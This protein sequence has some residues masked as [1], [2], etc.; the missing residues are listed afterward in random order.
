MQP[1][2]QISNAADLPDLHDKLSARYPYSDCDKQVFTMIVFMFIMI[3][4]KTKRAPSSSSVE[5]GPVS[6]QL[7]FEADNTLIPHDLPL[8]VRRRLNISQN[9]PE[10]QPQGRGQ[11][12]A[13]KVYQ[14]F[15]HSSSF[16]HVMTKFRRLSRKLRPG[17]IRLKRALEKDL[18]RGLL[19]LVI[20]TLKNDENMQ[21]IFRNIY[22]GETDVKTHIAAANQLDILRLT[23]PPQPNHRSQSGELSGQKESRIVTLLCLIAEHWVSPK[24]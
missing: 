20:V 13:W 3:L 15:S 21:N 7:A 8:E 5:N 16:P 18:S 2:D 1:V 23:D 9:R 19:D 14:R 17:V 11:K 24:V 12:H 4:N 10:S 6:H 22:R